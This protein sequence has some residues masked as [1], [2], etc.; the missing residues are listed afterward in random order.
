MKKFLFCIGAII[1][2]WGIITMCGCIFVLPIYLIYQMLTTTGVY[3]TGILRI[4]GIWLFTNMTSG[5][6]VVAGWILA[7]FSQ[8]D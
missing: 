4:V 2:F 7:I 1:V 5:M 6:L 3:F 8:E